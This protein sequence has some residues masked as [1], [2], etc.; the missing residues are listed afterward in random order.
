MLSILGGSDHVVQS[1]IHSGKTVSSSG[2]AKLG[3]LERSNA[4]FP[5]KSHFPSSWGVSRSLRGRLV[6]EATLAPGPLWP[7]GNSPDQQILDGVRQPW[8]PT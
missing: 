7:L 2:F 6:E 1:G 5:G 4:W 8:R 3:I